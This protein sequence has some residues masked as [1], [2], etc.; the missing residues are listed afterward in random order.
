[1]RG[2]MRIGNTSLMNKKNTTKTHSD[3]AGRDFGLVMP[4][5]GVRGSEVTD[6][7]NLFPELVD[8]E[9][10]VHNRHRGAAPIG[11]QEKRR[12]RREGKLI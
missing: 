1:M 10:V 8:L 6:G 4:G 9:E 12:N 3:E 5:C 11:G 2:R 7:A